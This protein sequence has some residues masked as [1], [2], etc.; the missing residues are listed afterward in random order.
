MLL[1]AILRQKNKTFLSYICVNLCPSVV[2]SLKIT[3]ISR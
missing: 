3:K 2:N 1:L